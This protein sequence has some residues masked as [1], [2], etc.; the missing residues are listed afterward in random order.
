MD[1]VVSRSVAGAALALAL[2]LGGWTGARMT[3]ATA[4]AV[5]VALAQK[6]DPEQA[7]R[8]A[9]E[10]E[11]SYRSSETFYQTRVDEAVAR[12]EIPAPAHSRLLEPNTFFH[13]ASP[14]DTRTIQ[15]GKALREAGFEI[16]VRTESIEVERRGIRTKN[17]H[18]L[19]KLENTGDKPLAYFL[20]LRSRDGDCQIRALTRY[21]AMVLLPDERAEISVCSGEHAVE[22]LDLRLMEVTELGALWV[23]KV[24]PQAVGHDQ[25]GARSHF[26]GP[27]IEMCAEIPANDI[28]GR[29]AVGETSWEDVVDFYSRH[30]CEVYRWWPGYRRIV[31]PLAALPV[32]PD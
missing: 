25:L 5:D 14:G 15:P 28:A 23:S 1:V 12:Y 31:E 16:R 2:A 9:L 29:I 18:T 4:D 22:V 11:A 3:L 17:T 6:I 21:D 8:E 26:P 19:A 27:G 7:Q 32:V 13:V 20:R 24:P 30:D 10:K